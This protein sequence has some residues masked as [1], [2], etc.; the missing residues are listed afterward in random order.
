MYLEHISSIDAVTLTAPGAANTAKQILI[1]PEQ[2]WQGWVMRL[3]TLGPDGHSPRHA[4][5]WPH[6]VYVRDGEGT[7]YVDGR[8]YPVEAGH[9]ACIPG[10][11]EH[12][13]T[14]RGTAEFS[15]ICIVPVEGNV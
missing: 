5:E 4:H 3:F 7:I 14:N 10:N 6:I 9:V 15:F 11:T 8:D 13:F 2:G 12:Q 1:G